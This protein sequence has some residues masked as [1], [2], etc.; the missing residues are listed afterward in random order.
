MI[1][2]FVRNLPSEF[3]QYF[4][5]KKALD[6]NSYENS[7][8]KQRNNDDYLPDDSTDRN[9]S[10]RKWVNEKAR[11]AVG[12]GSHHPHANLACACGWTAGAVEC[13]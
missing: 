12:F 2:G 13:D 7:R 11:E 10:T 5:K 1:S 4:R 3:L 8:K 6:G 9:A